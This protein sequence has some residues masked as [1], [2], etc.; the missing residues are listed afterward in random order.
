MEGLI[1]PENV[2]LSL[3]QIKTWIEVQKEHGKLGE[4]GLSENDVNIFLEHFHQNLQK[5]PTALPSSSL[6]V[7]VYLKLDYP[8]CK[9]NFNVIIPLQ[10]YLVNRFFDFDI[11]LGEVAGRH[12]EVFEKVGQFSVSFTTTDA[13]A[14]VDYDAGDHEA[15][16]VYESR[17]GYLLG[18]NFFLCVEEGVERALKEHPGAPFDIFCQDKEGQD[19]EVQDK[20]VQDKENVLD[21]IKKHNL[22]DLVEQEFK[23]VRSEFPKIV[24]MRFSLSRVRVKEQERNVAQCEKRFCVVFQ[25]PIQAAKFLSGDKKINLPIDKYNYYW[26]PFVFEEKDFTVEETDD[27]KL[28]E[29]ALELGDVV[30]QY[31]NVMSDYHLVD[32]KKSLQLDTN[33]ESLFSE[34][35]ELK[36]RLPVDYYL[37]KLTEHS[38]GQPTQKKSKK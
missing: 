7:Q 13:E 4:F 34:N 5:F 15:W 26:H 38:E 28:P 25:S 29:K 8:G 21:F 20:G 17:P 31:L 27:V 24:Y 22:D 19:K 9:Y 2:K 30:E 32:L 11:C 33:E 14:L 36:G 3:N 12:S 1:V 18:D 6:N 16:L 37:K 35:G 10:C 23:R